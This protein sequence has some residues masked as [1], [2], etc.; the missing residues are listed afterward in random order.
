MADNVTYLQRLR[1]LLA[2]I[3]EDLTEEQLEWA[4]RET[5]LAI[6]CKLTC[7]RARGQIK[8]H[9]PTGGTHPG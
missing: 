9:I 4:L 5:E 3:P 8:S 7:L 2:A 6:R 1:D